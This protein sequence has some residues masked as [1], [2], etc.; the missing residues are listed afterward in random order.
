MKTSISF[1]EAFKTDL[2]NCAKE[3]C[4]QGAIE[5]RETLYD[6]AKKSMDAFYKHYEPYYYDRTYGM[7]N[8]S[9][10]KRFRND[11]NTRFWGGV[12]LTPEKLVGN[13][14]RW[15]GLENGLNGT[16]RGYV[17]PWIIFNLVY[18]EGSHGKIENFG[19]SPLPKLSPTPYQRIIDSQKKFI[20]ELSKNT[21]ITQ[22]K[23]NYST[24]RRTK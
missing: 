11:N 16:S 12:M 20:K 14:Y 5:A 24:I 15:V 17:N 10:F 18:F 2:K 6:A 7:Y 9:Y 21:K 8:Q 13:Y 22:I 4:K 1:S 3:V 19:L 23:N